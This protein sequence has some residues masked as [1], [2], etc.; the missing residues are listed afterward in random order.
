MIV[1]SL[2]TRV[3][4]LTIFLLVFGIGTFA[5]LTLR[6]EQMQL[7]NSARESS[8]LLINTIERS[9][10]NAMRIGNT[11]DVQVILEMVG[12]NEKLV[13]VRIFHPHGVILKSS[14]PAEV[15]RLVNERDFKLFL[16][17]KWTGVFNLDGYG[18]VLS[19]VKPIY[20]D[21]S[22]TL[23]H[24]NKSRIIGLLNVNYSLAET[25]KRMVEL[26]KLFVLSTFA[27]ICFLS[28]A[29][30]AVMLKFVKKPLNRLAGNMAKVE[31]GDLSVRMTSQGQDEIGK[32]ITSFDSMVDR[33]DKAKK[34]LE[35]LHFQQMER[36]DRLASVGEMAAGIAHEIK[37]PLTGIAAAITVMKDDFTPDDGRVGIINE[38][39]EQISRLDKTVNDLLFFGKP[40]LPEP[41]C[42]DLNA[43]LRKIL[44]FASQ[45]RGGKDIEKKLELQ[46]DLPP[47]YVDAKQ[48]QQV[49]LNLFLNAVQAMP[50][51]G[52]L[53]VRSTLVRED[54]GDRIRVL[55]ND[56]GQGIPP[57]ILEKIFTP[58]FT[59]KAQGTGLGLAISHR[60]IAQ[61][62]GKLSVASEDGVG[63]TF[64]VELPAYC[65]RPSG[66][67]EGEAAHSCVT[68]IAPS[69]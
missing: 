42:T 39:L 54:G 16:N 49:F 58:F 57:N 59:T 46:E 26:T 24:G 27:I 62:G 36:A 21:K 22:C 48:M 7:I 29:I 35:D 34:E 23:C 52:T 11:A 3:I 13:G 10:Y 60:L 61:Q 63:T 9:V 55:V 43:S 12:Q 33:L 50:Q 65:P 45:H 64:T 66:P 14:Q 38:V 17:N 15:G 41:S 19:M 47:V 51:G 68:G 18:D 69:V 40:T 56:T 2:T 20:N 31:A 5:F 1:K 37:N 30:S 8:E 32:L 53:T 4:G 44:I 25:K 6:R 28:F 67:A